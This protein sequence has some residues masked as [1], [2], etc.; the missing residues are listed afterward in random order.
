MST[1]MAQPRLRMAK[2]GLRM[3]EE[4]L[5]MTE[6]GIAEEGLRMAHPC[7]RMAHHRLRI[8]KVDR[9]PCP[10]CFIHRGVRPLVL[11]VAHR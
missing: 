4:C 11:L 7:L 8:P 1:H 5:R 10:Q 6:D 3:A 9:S 2:K